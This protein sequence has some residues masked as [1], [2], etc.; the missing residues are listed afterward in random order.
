M[1]SWWKPWLIPRAKSIILQKQVSFLALSHSTIYTYPR[2][3]LVENTGIS[4][5]YESR[6]SPEWVW[7]V[8]FVQF[9][10]YRDTHLIGNLQKHL[11]KHPQMLMFHNIFLRITF[12]IGRF[13]NMKNVNKN[14]YYLQLD[15]LTFL[16]SPASLSSQA[17][18]YKYVPCTKQNWQSKHTILPY[19]SFKLTLTNGSCM[20]S[21][22]NLS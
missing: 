22:S 15:Y 13:R 10:S 19:H 17:S 3:P 7:Y 6:N 14:L 5:F 2:D 16:P 18:N 8:A 12:F 4:T 11:W 9:S 1:P 20:S 21:Y